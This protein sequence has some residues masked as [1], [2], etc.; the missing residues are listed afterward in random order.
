VG[1]GIE[2]KLIDQFNF[3]HLFGEVKYGI[4]VI[5]SSTKQAAFTNTSGGNQCL[6]NIGVRFG[7]FR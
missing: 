6:I 7:A 1:A 5:G 3:V 2:V 4:P